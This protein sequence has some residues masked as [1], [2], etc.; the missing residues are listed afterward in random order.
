MFHI[1]HKETGVAGA[2]AGTHSHTFYL[3]EVR[4]VKGEIVQCENKFSQTEESSGGWGL[5]G[6]LFEEEAE[7]HQTI[8]VG[9]GGVE[10][11]DV[12]GEEEAVGA[13]ELEI[14]DVT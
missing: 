14:V 10:G 1:P 9:D 12:H 8:P 6:P 7:S 4:G 11:L 3:E 13:R 5:F 2:H